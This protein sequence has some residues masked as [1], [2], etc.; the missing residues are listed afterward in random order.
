MHTSYVTGFGTH[1]FRNPHNRVTACDGIDEP[2]PGEVSGG[3]SYPPLD[4]RGEELVPK[5]S[6]PQYCYADHVDCYSLNEITIY[7]N[8][9]A[10]F[11]AA[12]FDR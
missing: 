11:A 6:A 4:P 7:W 5:G 10:V 9:S 2:I 1:A 3:P 8:S 12:Y